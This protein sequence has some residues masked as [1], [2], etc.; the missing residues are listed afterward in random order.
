MLLRS[1]FRATDANRRFQGGNGGVWNQ[2]LPSDRCPFWC[3]LQP[4]F[5]DSFLTFE[6][7]EGSTSYITHQIFMKPSISLLLAGSFLAA[8]PLFAAGP[9]DPDQW[10]S[11]VDSNK[12]VHF[13][14]TDNTFT[15]PGD[16]WTA[17]L[18]ILSG[19]DQGTAP[20]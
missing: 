15:P 5:P 14:S 13:V 3:P 4:I 18:N 17:T 2:V 9:Y 6:G 8:G 7:R 12:I 11:V 1:A 10:P 16:T 20:V 19:G